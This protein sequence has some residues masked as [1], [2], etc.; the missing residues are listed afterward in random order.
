MTMRAF[1]TLAPKVAT[2]LPECPHPLIVQHIRDAA[3]RVCERSLAWWYEEPPFALTPG[4]RRY[5]FPKPVDTEVQAVMAAALDGQPVHVAP[6]SPAAPVRA[7]L[8]VVD[9]GQPRVLTQVS[10][11]EFIV[12][13][14]PDSE[15]VYTLHLVYALKPARGAQEMDEQVF[16]MLELPIMHYALQTL[17]VIPDKPWTD[18]EVATYH[19]RQFLFTVTEARAQANLATFRTPLVAQAPRFA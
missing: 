11:H 10:A 17:L 3:R 13:P 2:S 16:D 1:S 12:L 8:S 19:A 9:P 4:E 5:T 6:V 14:P 7:N 18:R 15:K